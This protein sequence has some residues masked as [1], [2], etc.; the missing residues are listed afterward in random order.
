LSFLQLFCSLSLWERVRVRALLAANQFK[1]FLSLQS[2][3]P[4]L[5]QRERA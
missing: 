3:S 1:K 5:S 4:S 2:L